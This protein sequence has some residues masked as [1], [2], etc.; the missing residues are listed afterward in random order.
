M[1]ATKPSGWKGKKG[2]RYWH[3]DSAY[4]VRSICSDCGKETLGWANDFDQKYHWSTCLRVAGPRKEWRGYVDATGKACVHRLTV[5]NDSCFETREEALLALDVELAAQ[6]DT[7]Q[8]QRE[9]VAAMLREV[10]P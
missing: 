5:E 1:S 9:Q 4:G 2:D 7:I 3:K 10:T 6:Q 8:R